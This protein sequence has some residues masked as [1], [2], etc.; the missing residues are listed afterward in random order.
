MSTSSSVSLAYQQSSAGIP[1]SD[2]VPSGWQDSIIGLAYRIPTGH[3]A[4]LSIPTSLASVIDVR[5]AEVIIILAMP[6]MPP[7]HRQVW[8]DQQAGNRTTINTLII[9]IKEQ[10]TNRFGRSS[11][12]HQYHTITITWLSSSPATRTSGVPEQYQNR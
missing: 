4:Y 8:Q 6:S 11:V 1:T 10:S 2:Q 5:P 12:I 7:S 9:T 3:L